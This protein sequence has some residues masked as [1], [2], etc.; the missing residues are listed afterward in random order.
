MSVTLNSA[1]VRDLARKQPKPAKTKRKKPEDEEE[2]AVD[3]ALTAGR[4]Q[5]LDVWEDLLGKYVGIHLWWKKVEALKGVVVPIIFSM[6]I[7]DTQS[8][9][10]HLAAL[11][12]V[13]FITS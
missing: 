3:E 2:E 13:A 7:T 12:D 5:A 1:A 6:R 11:I 4:K 8:P 10:F 9:G